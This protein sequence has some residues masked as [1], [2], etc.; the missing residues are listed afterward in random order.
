[1][2]IWTIIASVSVEAL[3]Q[4]LALLSLK[5]LHLAS[6][7][8]LVLARSTLPLSLCLQIE[9]IREPII[10]VKGNSREGSTSRSR[11]S[12]VRCSA[13]GWYLCKVDRSLAGSPW[14]ASQV[15]RA[16]SRVSR[17]LVWGVPQS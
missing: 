15:Y 17:L 6:S 5:I 12:T 2:N 8:A 11:V 3:A 4:V 9:S 1:M 7:C 16:W 13:P 14:L 10:Q